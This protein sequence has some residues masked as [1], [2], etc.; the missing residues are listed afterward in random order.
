MDML[1]AVTGAVCIYLGYR[2]FC[3]SH[4]LAT[5]AAGAVL[6]LCGVGILAADARDLG[7]SAHHARP[8]WQRKSSQRPPA[9]SKYP[10]RFV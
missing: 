4:R 1:M 8:D 2:L 5:L 9:S 3:N 10:E 7:P 6:A